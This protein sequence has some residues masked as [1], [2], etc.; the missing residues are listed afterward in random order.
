MDKY[1]N[2]T[3]ECTEHG[4][5]TDD[6]GRCPRCHRIALEKFRDDYKIR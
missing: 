6:T 1:F 2:R 3:E 5:P 4:E